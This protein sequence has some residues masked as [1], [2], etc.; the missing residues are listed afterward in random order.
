MFQIQILSFILGKKPT[1]MMFFQIT[2]PPDAYEIESLNNEIR[3][4]IFLEEHFTESDYPFQIKPIF[5]TL[6]SIIEI[7]PQ[8]PTISFVFDVSIRKLL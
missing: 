5:S 4:N 2:I 8:G 6:G 7:S 1:Q 3:R